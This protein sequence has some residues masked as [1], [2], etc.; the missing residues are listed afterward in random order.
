MAGSKTGSGNMRLGT[1]EKIV[2]K[3]KQRQNQQSASSKRRQE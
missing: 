3:S 2:S 1:K